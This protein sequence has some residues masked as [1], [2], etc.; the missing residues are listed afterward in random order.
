MLKLLKKKSVLAAVFITGVVILIFVILGSNNFA[1]SA[2][3]TIFSPVLSLT[4]GVADTV[5][6]FKDYLIEMQVYREENERLTEELNA[7]NRSNRDIA[8]LKA[9]NERLSQLLDLKSSLKYVSVA[10]RVVSYE[11][12]NW[13]DTLVINKGTNDGVKVGAAV[14]S[15]GGIVGKVT[16]AGI[17]WARISSLLNDEN[18]VGVRIIRTGE[19]AVVE[20]DTELSTQKYCKLSFFDGTLAAGDALETTGEAGVYPEGIMVG[21]VIKVENEEYAVVE[22][23]V[24]FED[25][26]EVLVI[27]GVAEE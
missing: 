11:P 26:Y 6:E 20:G 19:L 18:A 23:A 15:S 4:A 8:E 25:L 24:D 17:G 27:T 9:E 3:K 2:V 13:Y 22:P 1:V 7:V 14:I 10:A 12:N 16:D 21:T 5:G